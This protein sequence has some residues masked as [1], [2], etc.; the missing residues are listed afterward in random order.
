MKNIIVGLLTAGIIA[1]M[2][3]TAMGG[4]AWHG[5]EAG[6]VIED[7]GDKTNASA[8]TTA[9]ESK[10]DRDI[11]KDKLKALRDKAGNVGKFKV[12]DNYKRK[13]ASCHGI[14]GE[15]TI[16]SKLIGLSSETVLQQL[17]DYKSGRK[18]NL[19]M[20]GLLLNMDETQMQEYADEISEFESR[21]A[22]LQ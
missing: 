4:P 20:K 6:H 19:I 3:M 8:Q 21:A 17:K 9:P 13:C 15:G 14:N 22:A 18:E 16:G 7:I 1:L 11:E 10:S 2:V 12:S 5:G